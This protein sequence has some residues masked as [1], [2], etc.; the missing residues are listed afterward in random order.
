M[1]ILMRC[2][3]TSDPYD[4]EGNEAP[5]GL[6]LRTYD[7]EAAG[8][9]GAA[10]FTSDVDEAMAFDTLEAAVQCWQTVPE[11]RPLREDGRPNRPLTAMT[12]EF[13]TPEVARGG[14]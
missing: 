9:R 3:A 6:F 10:T 11:S 8:G 7:P 1:S 5:I 4:A 2:M 13:V 14:E 12:M